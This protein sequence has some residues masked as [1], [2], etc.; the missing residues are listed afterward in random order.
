MQGPI[1]ESGGRGGKDTGSVRAHGPSRHDNAAPL[2]KLA[3]DRVEGG[4]GWER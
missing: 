2:T 4:H 1:I 3:G